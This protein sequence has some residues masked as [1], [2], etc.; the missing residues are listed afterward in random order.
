LND[1]QKSIFLTFGYAFYCWG[2]AFL[3]AWRL[4]LLLTQNEN[5]FS[6]SVASSSCI[7]LFLHSLLHLNQLCSCKKDWDSRCDF[8]SSLE[9]PLWLLF[10]NLI[11]YSLIQAWSGITCWARDPAGQLTGPWIELLLVDLSF[12][13]VLEN[14]ITSIHYYS[15]KSMLTTSRLRL[16]SFS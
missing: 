10:G 3:Q 8:S 11:V 5:L 9:N 4:V 15:I 6:L 14:R 7:L 1:L 2:F 12:S 13:L 16:V